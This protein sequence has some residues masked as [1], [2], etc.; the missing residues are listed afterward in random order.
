MGDGIC[1]ERKSEMKKNMRK[2]EQDEI[3]K[4]GN[5]DWKRKCVQKVGVRSRI[6]SGRKGRRKEGK[7]QFRH[8]KGNLY[9]KNEWDEE[10]TNERRTEGTK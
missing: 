10:I 5:K 9:R 2:E 1:I 8:G 7:I 4:E 3:R 6:T